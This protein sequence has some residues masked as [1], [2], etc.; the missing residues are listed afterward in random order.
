MESAAI[1]KVTKTVVRQFPEMQGIE[2]TVRDQMDQCTLTYSGAAELPGG[3][4]LKRIV[5][6][7]A[8]SEGEV[9]RMSTSR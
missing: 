4:T 2:P 3:K 7:V 9:I 1:A 5:R 6:V 8:D